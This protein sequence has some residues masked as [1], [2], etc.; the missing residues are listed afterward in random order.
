MLNNTN[1]I[2]YAFPVVHGYQ[3]KWRQQRPAKGVIA[4][5]LRNWIGTRILEA[6]VGVGALTV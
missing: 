4:D 2:I 6:S 1:T 3:L 5:E